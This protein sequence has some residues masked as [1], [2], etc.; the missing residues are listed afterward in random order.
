M[1]A[2]APQRLKP[3]SYGADY[4]N[5]I[6]AQTLKGVAQTKGNVNPCQSEDWRYRSKDKIEGQSKTR[7]E[8]GQGSIVGR[9][10]LSLA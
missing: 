4:A 9:T 7:G 5:Q 10:M 8:S 6:L 1:L 2:I 3:H